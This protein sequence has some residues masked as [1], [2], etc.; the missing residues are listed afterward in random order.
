M[1]R[2]AV[3]LTTTSAHGAQPGGWTRAEGDGRG[4]VRT[5]GHHSPV[6]Q[7]PSSQAIIRNARRL[8]AAQGP[9]GRG[10]PVT[11]ARRRACLAR[12]A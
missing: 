8:D 5:P 3:V 1:V 2:V 7:H 6:R 9:G 12:V 10:G 4:C 11:L